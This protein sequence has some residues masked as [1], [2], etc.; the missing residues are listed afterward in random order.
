V[1]L[2]WAQ[3]AVMA[4]AITLAFAVRFAMY[5][6]RPV[7][8]LELP[9]FVFQFLYVSPLLR[10][11]AGTDRLLARARSGYVLPDLVPCGLQLIIFRPRGTSLPD[12]HRGLSLST[13]SSGAGTTA[14][15]GSMVYHVLEPKARPDARADPDHPAPLVVIKVRT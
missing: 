13:S 1:Q 7:T 10:R 3:M 8:N 5:L 15:T 12:A 4:G 6:Y 14:G 9:L 11:S 2:T